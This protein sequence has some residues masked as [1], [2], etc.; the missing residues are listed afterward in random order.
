MT[1][2][3]HRTKLFGGRF[4]A[5]EVHQKLAWNGAKCP[6]GAPA[7][8]RINS[9]IPIQDYRTR[10]T[11]FGKLAMGKRANNPPRYKTIWGDF[12]PVAFVYA[13]KGCQKIAEIAA[14]RAPSYYHVEIDRGPGQD[15]TIVQVPKGYGNSVI[16]L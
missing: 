5:E 1:E 13:C 11:E 16:E 10:L 7:A 3:I 12:V 9:F 8:I 14:A 4:T 2:T 15:K 6:C